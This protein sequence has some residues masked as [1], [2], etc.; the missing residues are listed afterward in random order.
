[1]ATPLFQVV[2][3]TLVE[4]DTSLILQRQILTSTQVLPPQFRRVAAHSV[5]YSDKTLKPPFP[6]TLQVP[7][8]K[9][10]GRLIEVT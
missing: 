1:M 5:A 4:T 7:V 2:S 6:H 8:G 10:L 9:N 3:P